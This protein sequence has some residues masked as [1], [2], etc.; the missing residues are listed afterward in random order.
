MRRMR[1]LTSSLALLLALS[2]CSRDKRGTPEP[3]DSPAAPSARG[4]I[5][6]GPR[7]AIRDATAVGR[8]EGRAS[9]TVR[10]FLS[11]ITPADGLRLAIRFDER[12]SPDGGAPLQYDWAKTSASM[13]FTIRGPTGAPRV[14]QPAGAGRAATSYAS[15]VQELVIDA[16]GLGHWGEV[17][18]WKAP[19]EGLFAEPG[20]HAARVEG[21]FFAGGTERPFAVDAPPVEVVAASP[22]FRSTAE[23]AALAADAVKAEIGVA[24]SAAPKHA[25]LLAVDDVEDGRWLRFDLAGGRGG[26]DAHLVDVRISPAGKVIAM[27]DFS[28]F[29]CV[30]EGTRVATPSGE[31]PVETLAP[32][33]VVW[34]YDTAGERRIATTVLA[35][36]SSVRASLVRIGDAETTPEHPILA[37]GAFVPAASVR[38]GARSH[39]VEGRPSFLPAPAPVARI[40]PVFDLSV[41]WPHTFFAGGVLVH[42]KAVGVPL[43]P[44]DPWRGLFLRR[45]DAAP[46]AGR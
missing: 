3:G 10:L 23:L 25:A 41:G 45:T 15:D 29:T 40:A 30:A 16:A 46:E 35:A 36:R 39:D 43:A 2:S 21:T 20:K 31:R 6:A 17:S 4:V 8:G 5:V 42:N 26:Y 14:L 18:P 34:G 9:V 24:T 27:R 22:S 37:D 12:S 19:P 28:Y 1:G 7:P 38:A 13:R 44:G 33:D 11:R 32:G